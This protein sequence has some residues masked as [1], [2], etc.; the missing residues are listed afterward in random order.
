MNTQNDDLWE[1]ITL[2]SMPY[3][4]QPMQTTLAF[5]RLIDVPD[6]RGEKS[7]STKRE[8]LFVL[9]NGLVNASYFGLVAQ[10]TYGQLVVEL[11]AILYTLE[12]YVMANS[13]AFSF[14]RKR[15]DNNNADYETEVEIW[16][17][18]RR[19]CLLIVGEA[20]RESVL[21]SDD[22]LDEMIRR[23]SIADDGGDV[24]RH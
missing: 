12:Y 9:L 8:A 1:V 19:Y 22:R 11:H 15:I 13:R 18:I 6:G 3:E 7:A 14:A 5:P 24:Q 16:N 17:V 10:S 2:F 4:E 21:L 20:R 23:Y